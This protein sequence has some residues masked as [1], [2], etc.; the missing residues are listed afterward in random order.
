MVEVPES[1]VVRS[2]DPQFFG[3]GSPGGFGS[4]YYPQQQTF[5][6]SG[7]NANAQTQN[8]NSGIGGIGGSGS[9]ANAAAQSQNFNQGGFGGGGS[10]SGIVTH[11]LPQPFYAVFFIC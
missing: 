10:G 5:G 3:Q 6:A 11:C 1:R 7:A 2:A 4:P 8:F 9:A